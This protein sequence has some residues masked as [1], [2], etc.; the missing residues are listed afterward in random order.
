MQGKGGQQGECQSRLVQVAGP[1]AR[2]T[3]ECDSPACSPSTGSDPTPGFG[4]C[5]QQVT[6]RIESHV[7]RA[8]LT[9]AKMGRGCKARG[10]AKSSSHSRISCRKAAIFLIGPPPLL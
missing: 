6:R 2:T 9:M 7:L 4:C 3:W 1:F 10:Y 5:I 8:V